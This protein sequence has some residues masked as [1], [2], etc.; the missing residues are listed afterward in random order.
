MRKSE[1]SSG[2]QPSRAHDPTAPA[3]L[4]GIRAT[5][6]TAQVEGSREGQPRR[7]G[8][9]CIS[10][11]NLSTRA[12]GVPGHKAVKGTAPRAMPGSGG[13]RPPSGRAAL[14]HDT[15][16]NFPARFLKTGSTWPKWLGQGSRGKPT[17]KCTRDPGPAPGALLSLGHSC[18][19][20]RTPGRW[21]GGRPCCAPGR[22]LT[23]ART[24][25]WKGQPVSGSERTGGWQVSRKSHPCGEATR[26]KP[27]GS[28][29]APGTRGRPVALLLVAF[30]EERGTRLARPAAGEPPGAAGQEP[31]VQCLQRTGKSAIAKNLLEEREPLG[32]TARITR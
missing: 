22:G 5:A 25:G 31:A 21:T 8:H 3:W 2:S 26:R 32:L 15:C 17:Q 24:P 23:A 9:K 10:I 4:L 18:H 29:I 28:L 14:C 19:S 6:A 12:P 16:G 13:P 7:P 20:P 1:G 30:G 11:G 27:E